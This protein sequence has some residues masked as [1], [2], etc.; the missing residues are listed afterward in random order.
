MRPINIIGHVSILWSLALKVCITHMSCLRPLNSKITGSIEKGSSYVFTWLRWDFS[1]FFS[2]GLAIFSSRWLIL[3]R[4][5]D[6]IYP[7]DSL[8]STLFCPFHS[9]PFFFFNLKSRAQFPLALCLSILSIVVLDLK[10][11]PCAR[12]LGHYMPGIVIKSYF[13][14]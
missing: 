9:I 6:H 13:K 7:I 10:I 8:D 4:C 12:A 3:L 1:S 11:L 14:F 2:P 5:V